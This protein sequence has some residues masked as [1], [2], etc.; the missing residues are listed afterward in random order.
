MGASMIQ[1]PTQPRWVRSIGV[2]PASYRQA[3]Q[4]GLPPAWW[5]VNRRYTLYMVRELSSV[6]LALWSVRLLIQLD[7]VRRGRDA[8]DAVVAAQRRPPW[9]AFHLITLL[10]ATIHSV[11]FLLAAGKGPT[12]HVRRRRVSERTIAAGAFAGWAAASLA[13]LLVLL[14]G[15]RGESR[16]SDRGSA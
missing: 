1:A 6:F 8:Y 10:F 11:T 14:M 2:A 13:V 5:R 4:P 16:G 15:G 7:Q 3:T 12:L 9:I